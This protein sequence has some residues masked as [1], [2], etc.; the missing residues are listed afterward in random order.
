MRTQNHD[1]DKLRRCS[2]ER[3]CSGCRHPPAPSPSVSRRGP[4]RRTAERHVRHVYIYPRVPYGSVILCPLWLLHA[5]EI[6]I[7]P[8]SYGARYFPP[9]SYM[10]STVFPDCALRKDRQSAS[11]R[12][13]LRHSLY[14]STRRNQSHRLSLQVTVLSIA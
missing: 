10:Q 13:L 5:K 14:R 8:G 3:D 9:S 12:E 6:V 11:E 1:A 7:Y 2:G 4:Q